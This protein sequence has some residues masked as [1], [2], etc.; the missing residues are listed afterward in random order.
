MANLGK[1][2]DIKEVKEGFA[3]NYLI[4]KAL[5][6]LP[7]DKKAQELRESII[8]IN[9]QKKEKASGIEEKA[10]SIEGKKY[11]FVVKTDA[12][13]NPYSSVTPKEIARKIGI[14]ENLVKVHFKKI[15]I[16][17]LKIEFGKNIESNVEIVIKNK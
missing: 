2:G 15:G 17:P 8:S 3:K 16:F 13:G 1:A 11:V 9:K 14:D 4:P 6:V 5:A 10:K 12:K 7:G